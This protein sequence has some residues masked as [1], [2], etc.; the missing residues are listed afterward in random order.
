MA[1]P[2]GNDRVVGR[3]LGGGRG[4]GGRAGSA[5][6]PPRLRRDW[7]IA[8]AFIVLLPCLA[9]IY[10]VDQ[11]RRT[12]DRNARDALVV[13]Q[14]ADAWARY[15]STFGSCERGNVLRTATNQ[16]ARALRSISV[17]LDSFLESSADL[18]EGAGR[19]GLAQ[20]ARAAQIEVATIAARLTLIPLADCEAVIPKPSVPRPT[21]T[22]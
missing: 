18:R 13:S 12:S 1:D 21:R 8:L 7:L 20:Q 6:T 16:Q 5:L 17:V 4:G 19:P 2:L 9:G 3:R 22:A 10:M 14:A 15:D 11:N